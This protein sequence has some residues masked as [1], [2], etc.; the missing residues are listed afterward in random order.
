M[1][2]LQL[3]APRR[4]RSPARPFV[5]NSRDLLRS[6]SQS[7]FQRVSPRTKDRVC[8]VVSPAE[9]GVRMR[10]LHWSAIAA[11][12]LVLGGTVAP[13]AQPRQIQ[14]TKALVGGLLV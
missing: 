9:S 3:R 5:A 13:R 7:S 2:R 6:D 4:S 12:V 10:S 8:V 14:R 11:L 1:P